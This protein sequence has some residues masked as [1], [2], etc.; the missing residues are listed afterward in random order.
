MDLGIFVAPQVG[1]TYDDQLKMARLAEVQE[2]PVHTDAVQAVGRIKVD[3]HALG[4]ASLAASG[5]KFHGPPG[6]GVLLVR[7][8]ATLRPLTAIAPAGASAVTVPPAQ[9]LPCG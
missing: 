4:V 9:R 5:H 7:N 3:F 8:G 1:A 6:V 2:V